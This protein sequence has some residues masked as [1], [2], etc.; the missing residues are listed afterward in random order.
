LFLFLLFIKK[1]TRIFISDNSVG[2]IVHAYGIFN[3][4]SYSASQPLK[5]LARIYFMPTAFW[6]LLKYLKKRLVA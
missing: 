3:L 1:L 5:W 6:P 2:K 4:I